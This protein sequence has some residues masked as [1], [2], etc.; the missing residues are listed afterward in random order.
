VQFTDESTVTPTGWAWYFS[1]EAYTEPWTQM[2]GETP[3]TPRFCHRSVVLEDGSIILMGG[4]DGDYRNDVWRLTDQGTTWTQM[5]PA[6][7]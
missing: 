2:A 3:W 6:A 1:D 4:W 5:T 7:E